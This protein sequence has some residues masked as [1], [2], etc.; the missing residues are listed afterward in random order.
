MI[1][2]LGGPSNEPRDFLAASRLRPR[3]D[4]NAAISIQLLCGSVAACQYQASHENIKVGLIDKITRV[5]GRRRL[6]ICGT[7]ADPPRTKW[8]LER[9]AYREAMSVGIREPVIHKE[10]GCK[11]DF[12]VRRRTAIGASV[13]KRACLTNIRRQRSGFEEQ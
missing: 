9:R 2:R 4:L 3:T 7:Q 5:D 12:E 10:R 13:K 8:M 11:Q 1:E 6:R